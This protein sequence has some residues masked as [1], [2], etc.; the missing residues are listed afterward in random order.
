MGDLM[1][2][3]AFESLN[4]NIYVVLLFF[5]TELKTIQVVAFVMATWKLKLT[6]TLFS[7]SDHYILSREWRVIV[8]QGFVSLK[9]YHPNF[10]SLSLK[11]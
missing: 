4:V 6:T 5:V 9:K 8:D 7:L 3:M 1:V 11:N 10:Q 2:L